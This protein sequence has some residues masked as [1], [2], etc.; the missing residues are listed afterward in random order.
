MLSSYSVKTGNNKFENFTTK[1]TRPITLD[2]NVQYAVGLNRIINMSFTWFNIN[3]SYN[4]QLINY[5]KDNGTSF[6]DITIPA[7]VWNYC[8]INQHIKKITV[9]KHSNKNDEYP[10][11][12]EFNETTFRVTITMKQNYQLDLTHSNFYELIGVDKKIIK[13]KINVG[14]RVPNLS[15]DTKILNIHCDLVN[16]SLVDGEESG[17]TYSFSTSVLKPSYSFTLEPKR[18]TYIPIDKN[19]IS[20]IRI[21][22]SDGKRG[23][24][25]LNGADTSFYVISKRLN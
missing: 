6:T 15:Q 23:V 18:V 20:S 5:S 13:D 14:P 4:N 9:I 10:I 1:F 2:S 21:Y 22:I 16:H 11:N 24:I 3:S 25:N 19:T 17:I 7:G 8:D 12:L